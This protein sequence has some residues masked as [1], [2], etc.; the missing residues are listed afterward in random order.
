MCIEEGRD[1]VAEARQI[2]TSNE[3]ERTYHL[4]FSACTK[5]TN[6]YCVQNLY[7]SNLLFFFLITQLI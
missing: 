6:R 3:V 4:N 5:L 2:I 1:C 7:I